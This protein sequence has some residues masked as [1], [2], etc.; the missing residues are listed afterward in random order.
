MK[1]F[2][3]IEA[4]ELL[5]TLKTN[6]E[7]IFHLNQTLKAV[8]ADIDSLI[9]IWGEDVYKHNHVDN[10]YYTDLAS[11]QQEVMKHLQDEM[12]KINQLGCFVKDIERGL[13]DFYYELNDEVVFLCWRYGED[14]INHWHGLNSGFTG[15][16]PLRDLFAFN[17]Q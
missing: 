2:S 12:I 17:R 16:R 6:L 11:K 10:G 3:V 5:P 9:D 4:E 14:K 7:K 1:I 13:V 8:S 15:R